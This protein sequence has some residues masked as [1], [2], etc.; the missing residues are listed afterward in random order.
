MLLDEIAT[1]DIENLHLPM[2][3]DARLRLIVDLM[4]AAPSER[5]TLDGWATRVGLSERTFVRLISRETG[6]SFARW[7]QQLGVMLAVQ[8]LAGGASIQRVAADLGYAE[9]AQLRNHVP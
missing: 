4:M 2:P 6:M 3:T 7:R 8:W 9:R 1:A 5:G